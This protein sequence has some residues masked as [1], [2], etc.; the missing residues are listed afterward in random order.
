MSNLRNLRKQYHQ[1][2]K[3]EVRRTRTIARRLNYNHIIQ[4]LSKKKML[5]LFLRIMEKV[6]KVGKGACRD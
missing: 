5:D 3:G 1:D 2:V 4:H 6:G